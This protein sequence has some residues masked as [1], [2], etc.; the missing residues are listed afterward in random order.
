MKANH[1]TKRTK[2]KQ[3]QCTVIAQLSVRRADTKLLCLGCIAGLSI[4]RLGRAPRGLGPGGV[5][6]DPDKL[7]LTRFPG[8]KLRSC[9][10]LGYHRS[11]APSARNGLKPALARV[12]F[13]I[14]RNSTSSTKEASQTALGA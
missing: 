6:K 2:S 13:Y 1:G 14:P 7:D 4:G 9:S 11:S 10:A 3:P 8:N 5:Q 12:P